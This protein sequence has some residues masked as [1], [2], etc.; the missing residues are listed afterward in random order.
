MLG[1]VIFRNLCVY[2]T[3]ICMIGGGLHWAFFFTLVG[4][5]TPF[6]VYAV[7]EINNQLNQKYDLSTPKNV[8]G[9]NVFNKVMDTAENTVSTTRDLE[10][11]V[12][13][14]PAN[15]AN[16]IDFSDYP[17]LDF[18]EVFKN[19]MGAGLPG[20]SNVK[21][22]SMSNGSDVDAQYYEKG[23]VTF[24]RDEN[25]NLVTTTVP[26]SER[27]AKVTSIKGSE[28]FTNQQGRDDEEFNAPANY[29]DEDAYIEDLKVQYGKT[30]SG[31][32]MSSSAYRAILKGVEEN[33]APKI[34]SN[35]YFFEKGN[36]A[37]DDAQHGNGIWSQSCVDETVTETE[38]KRIPVWEP[39]ICQ[40][41]NHQNINFCQVERVLEKNPDTDLVKLEFEGNFGQSWGDLLVVSVNFKDGT[42]RILDPIAPDPQSNAQFSYDVDQVDFSLFCERAKS[43]VTLLSSSNWKDS[44]V[45]KKRDESIN[46]VVEQEPSCNNG[47]EGVFRISDRT[48]GKYYD[49]YDITGSFQF[50]IQTSDY[51]EVFIE[52]PAGCAS[53]IGWR[54]GP[55]PCEGDSCYQSTAPKNEF[56]TFDQ[57]EIIEQGTNHYPQWVIESLN[58]M[59]ETDPNPAKL[60]DA[61]TDGAGGYHVASWVINAKGYS[62]DPLM[63]NDYC[64]SILNPD[65]QE[66]EQKCYSYEEFT[67]VEG[68]CKQYEDNALCEK[69]GSSCVEGWLDES[70]GTCYMYSDD[71]RCDVSNP[72]EITST[73][74]T[75][76]CSSMLPC[77]GNDCSYGEEESNSQFEKA[78]L[79]GSIAQQVDDDASCANSDPNTCEIFPGEYEYCSWE[80]SGLGNNCCEAPSGIDYLALAA[81]GYKMMQ[82]EAFKKVSSTLSG[83]VTE[84]MAD[85]IGGMYSDF[86]T[87]LV[88]GW[89]AGASAVVD[90]ASSV[91]G[92]PEFMQGAV[93]A[94]Q[95]GGETAAEGVVDTLMHQMQQQLYTFLNDLLPDALADMIFQE[96][97]QDMINK[98]A[99]QAGDLVLGEMASTIMSII[100]FVGLIYTIYNVVK[101]LAN[102][103]TQCDDNEQDMG[104]KLAQKQCFK[105]G[106]K[107][108]AKDVLGVCYLRR[109]DWCCYSSM[110]SRI[111][112]DQGSKQIGKDMAECPGFTIEEF[113]RIDFDRLDLSEWLSTM[114]EAD[115]LST[116]GYDIDRLTGSG[117]MLGNLSCEGSDDPECQEMTRKTA[118]ERAAEQFNGDASGIS[119]QLKDTFDP[120]QIDCSVYPR[121]MICELNGG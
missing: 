112:A 78:M 106:N 69:T 89:N 9:T 118:D 84:Q 17:E 56:C 7:D 21:A 13:S 40:R 90:F 34:K 24:S 75:N 120:D 31:K 8:D 5:I 102:L 16:N 110:L 77:M 32:T 66:F 94:I 79:L 22:P 48:T 15:P 20:E 35:A 80:V 1:R 28:V 68:S 11:E 116:T 82:S 10:L 29:G 53:S 42:A 26:E 114:Y 63:G 74:T 100:S 61:Q 93:D 92:D 98:G 25:G 81:M 18:Q 105:V 39:K 19:A 62:C 47:L 60:Y 6:D 87:M 108:C 33:P 83:G 57:W 45:G 103:L 41:P 113:G 97:T 109:Q 101:I 36:Q 55:Y 44:P 117:R 30:E 12:L 37:I 67:N 85:K 2:F 38:Q 52:N 50:E 76:V 86:T 95:I 72:I 121:P 71:Y 23:G 59:F 43:R 58:Q 73:K 119:N 115:I 64:V 14:R 99:A 3:S 70:S 104:V 51:R 46:I 49:D 91:M 54:P 65:T 88:D 96:A 111:I 107:Y 27:G 4:A